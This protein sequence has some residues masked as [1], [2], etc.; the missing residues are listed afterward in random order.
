MSQPPA[1]NAG[2]LSTKELLKAGNHQSMM[3]HQDLNALNNATIVAQESNP[4]IADFLDA[5]FGK[6]LSGGFNEAEFAAKHMPLYYPK[7]MNAYANA[8]MAKNPSLSRGDALSSAKYT[9]LEGQERILLHGIRIEAVRKKI[10]AGCKPLEVLRQSVVATTVIESVLFK[11]PQFVHGDFLQ[12]AGTY[13]KGEAS[14]NIAVQFQLAAREATSGM[15]MKPT[16]DGRRCANT[17]TNFNKSKKKKGGRW[18]DL[19]SYRDKTNS[20]YVPPGYCVFHHRH[21]SGCNRGNNCTHKHTMW[22]D[23]EL[24]KPN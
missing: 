6:A 16:F 24:A 14:E 12:I 2:L 22:T 11:F 13:V 18:I 1:D 8:K 15:P 3:N 17:S 10:A 20:S 9:R 7:D 4:P 19:K 21:P 23:D 5:D